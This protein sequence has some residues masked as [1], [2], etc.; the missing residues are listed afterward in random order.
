MSSS[1]ASSRGLRLGLVLAALVLPLALAGCSGFRPVYGTT[2]I[3]SE[4]LAFNYGD[5]DSR[6]EQIII[7]ELELRL[8]KGG[9]P[10]APV[11]RVTASAA[12]RALTRTAVVKPRT[13]YEMTVSATYTVTSADGDLLLSG[14]RRAT[15][16]Y[17]TVGQVLADEAAAKDATERA[18]RTVADTIRLAILGG[19]A[20]PVR[21]A[22]FSQ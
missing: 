10:G 5:P 18:G 22:A 3:T 6:L 19:L 20:T 9:D 2:G 21:E 14:S 13:Q 7:K 15:A 8:G 16:S 1:R 11:V 12:A 17:E 4:R